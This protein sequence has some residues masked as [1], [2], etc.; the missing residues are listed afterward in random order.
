MVSLTTNGHVRGDGRV[1]NSDQP[2]DG[3]Q[4]VGCPYGC[5]KQRRRADDNGDTPGPRDRNVEAVEVIQE[6]HAAR[7]VFDR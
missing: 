5:V 2:V 6:A 3:A 7:C 4:L 1:N